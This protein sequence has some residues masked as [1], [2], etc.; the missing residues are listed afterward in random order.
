M[1]YERPVWIGHFLY[2]EDSTSDEGTRTLFLSLADL[3]NLEVLLYSI[4]IVNETSLCTYVDFLE[5]L[6]SF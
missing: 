2:P 1:T 4:A 5:N 6:I 3:L